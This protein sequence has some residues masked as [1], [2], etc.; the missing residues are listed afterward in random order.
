MSARSAE[1]A[2]E[3][4][5]PQLQRWVYRQG[6]QR[7]RPAQ[8]A[9]IPV[10]ADGRRDVVIAAA[11]AA[12]K[13]EAAFLPVL[14]ALAHERDA[15]RALPV[16]LY[17]APLKAL[18]NDQSRRLALMVQTLDIPIVAWH[19]DAG[20]QGKKR[21]LRQPG[22]VVQ[23]TPES[24]E[25]ILVNR[26]HA[27]PTLFQGLRYIVVD[28]LHAFIERERGMQLQSLMHRIELAVGRR[29]PRVGLSATLGDMGLAC[30]FLRP[31]HGAA[32]R[33]IR[34]REDRAGLHLQLR[35]YRQTPPA[36]SP[37]E[38]SR[39]IGAAR[40][41]D[42]E[43]LLDGDVLDIADH[44]YRHLRGSNN[45]IF[46][47]ARSNVETFADLLRRAC[48]HD[49]VP[50]AFF[51]HHGSLNKESRTH[52]EAALKAGTRPVSAVC[53]STL[54]M[55]VDIGKVA[56]IAQIGPPPAVSALR[57]RLGRSGRR[58]EPAVLRLYVRE[59]QIDARS[60]LQDRLRPALFQTVAMVQLLLDGWIEPPRLTALHLSTLVQQ[61]LSVIAQHGGASALSLWRVLG[62]DHAPFAPVGR[63]R[64]VRV[65]RQMGK[66]GLLVQTGDGTLL[67]GPAAQVLV[68]HYGFYT[69]FASSEEYTLSAS[70]KIIGQLPL[71]SALSEGSLIIFGGRRWRVTRV[72]HAQKR[73]DLVPGHGGKAPSFGGSVGAVHDVVRQT[74][75][76]LLCAGPAPS[77]LNTTARALY[78][79]GQECFNALG[80]DRRCLVTDKGNTL[81]LPW[82]GDVVMETLAALLALHG[83]DA[84]CEGLCL[85][86][87]D[88]SASEVGAALEAIATQPMPC[89]EALAVT[90]LNKAD[91]RYSAWLDD[92]LLCEDW[93]SRRIDVA[94]AVTMA[95][96]LLQRL[97]A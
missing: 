54:E 34:A 67:H 78:A 47:N 12:G 41:A 1:A 66:V 94:A 26:G 80:L 56:S 59:R 52:I 32:V 73:I 90:V 89:G 35:G 60:A 21:F 72:Q 11:T 65:L 69:A 91:Q 68:N 75:F 77:Y 10:I 16:A 38:A 74:M 70:G 28:E 63:E 76:K 87:G 7:L 9:A 22:G 93:A 53:T 40:W 61:I 6:W 29:V 51:P 3:R 18:I 25:S 82:C 5:H 20:Q 43:Q 8:A 14:S 33:Q 15:T 42:V 92:A 48:E 45:L 19:G 88:A 55:G 50:V 37:D 27:V 30:E 36:Q 86:A 13:T 2:F 62:A 4:L 44:L 31:G 84:P 57:Q 95:E 71:E 97:T 24:L 49:G 79:E 85:N 96:Q 46:A 17:I 81:L 39:R 83:V 23:I 64:F 58:G